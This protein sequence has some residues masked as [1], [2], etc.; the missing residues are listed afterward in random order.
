VDTNGDFKKVFTDAAGVVCP[1]HEIAVDRALDP[2]ML[3]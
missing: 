1:A 3:R 2:V